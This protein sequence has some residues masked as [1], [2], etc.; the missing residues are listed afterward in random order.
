MGCQPGENRNEIFEECKSSSPQEDEHFNRQ[1]RNRISAQA[2]EKHD[3]FLRKKRVSFADVQ[4]REYSR[5]VGDHPNVVGGLPLS[6]DWKHA[7]NTTIDIDQ[8]ECQRQGERQGCKKMNTTD[9]ICLLRFFGFSEKDLRNAE[10]QRKIRLTQEWAY[11]KDTYG[12]P[13][14]FPLTKTRLILQ[15]Y[16]V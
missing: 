10:I 13:K 9:R 8:Y 14:G 15:Q 4:V 7:G 12:V 1:L 5:T 16:V 6:I 3:S 2:L 11:G